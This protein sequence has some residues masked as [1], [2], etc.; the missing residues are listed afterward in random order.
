MP[1]RRRRTGYQ[2]AK[3]YNP[4]AFVFGSLVSPSLRSET[5]PGQR[6]KNDSPPLS[7]TIKSLN[8]AM[9]IISWF[10]NFY[11]LFFRAMY[12]RA[13]TKL[14]SNESSEGDDSVTGER[15]G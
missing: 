11:N 6:T 14:A 15:S 9:I 1:R 12:Y 5:D 2:Q 3:D 8:A 4:D 7:R 10:V 13:K